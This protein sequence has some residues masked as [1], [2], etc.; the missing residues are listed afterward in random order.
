MIG[1]DPPEGGL[2]EY[3]GGYPDRCLNYMPWAT[4]MD[5]ATKDAKKNFKKAPRAPWLYPFA[6]AYVWASFNFE[7]WEGQSV[8]E[9]FA[10]VQG[11]VPLVEVAMG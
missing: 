6:H 8:S 9:V 5:G 1:F 4:K 7:M 10:G 2:C 3:F 11:A